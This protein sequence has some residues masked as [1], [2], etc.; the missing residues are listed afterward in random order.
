MMEDPIKDAE[1]RAAIADEWAKYDAADEPAR[2]RILE[3]IESLEADRAFVMPLEEVRRLNR[4]A[5]LTQEMVNE[6]VDKIMADLR[7]RFPNVLDGA[8]RRDE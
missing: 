8:G 7:E 4:E 3:R 6:S 5:G 2:E 1:L